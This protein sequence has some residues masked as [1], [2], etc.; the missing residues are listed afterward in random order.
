MEKNNLLVIDGGLVKSTA[1]GIVEGM[2]IVFGSEKEPDQST[3]HDFFTAESYVRNK[4]EFQVPLFLEHGLGLHDEQIGEATLS[5]QNDGWK[6]VAEIDTSTDIGQKVYEATKEKQFG[7]STGA[8]QHMIKRVSKSNGANFLK[9]WVV[10]ELS[11]TERPAE[12]KAVVQSVKSIT[13]DGQ[14]TYGPAFEERENATL[15]AIYGEDGS[16]VWDV[17][18]G[19]PLP[20]EDTIKSAN[21]KLEIKSV[22]G[23]VQYSVYQYDENAETGTEISVYEWGGVANFIDHLGDIVQK[24]KDGI[25][26]DPEKDFDSRVRKV[27]KDMLPQDEE[28][29]KIS[30]LESEIKA[31]DD[32]LTD[33]RTQLSEANDALIKAKERNAQ[34]E[35][36]A[37]AQQTIN[38][39]KKVK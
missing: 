28:N 19:L 20:T 26:S 11:L 39:Y 37:D 29:P 27:V 14:I 24:A 10:G 3:F 6:A 35:I 8:M 31:K 1:E 16:K 23:S 32:D 5:K 22:N 34:L 21:H 13:E 12:R 2:G 4:E 30:E 9:K 17:D 18:S 7:F 15:M 33:V 25:K 38:K 36:L